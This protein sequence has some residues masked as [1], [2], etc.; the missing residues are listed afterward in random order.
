MQQTNLMK[1]ELIVGFILF[2]SGMISLLYFVSPLRLLTEAIEPHE[3][4]PLFAILGG[5]ALICGI[6][7][8]V[9]NRPRK[10]GG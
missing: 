2:V 7:L 10:A 6:A 3:T 9:A 8:L 5:V 1:K 4:R